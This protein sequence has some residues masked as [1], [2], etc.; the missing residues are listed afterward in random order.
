MTVIY[1][2]HPKISAGFDVQVTA[3]G[4][5]W[6]FT[7]L[8]LASVGRLL[9]RAQ[10]PEFDVEYNGQLYAGCRI[11]DLPTDD[12]LRFTCKEVTKMTSSE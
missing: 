1:L 4:D 9:G 5:A 8:D 7:G 2:R 10:K 12:P 3:S 6:C 11:A